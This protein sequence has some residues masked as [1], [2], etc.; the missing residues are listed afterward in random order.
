[1][2]VVVAV[3]AFRAEA[4]GMGII[5]LMAAVAVLRNL[6]LVIAAAMAGET[7]DLRVHAQEVIA[8]FLQM[9]VFR[10]L[11]LLGHVAL[12]AIL[13]ARAAMLIVG[14]MTAIAA[15]RHRL[16]AA[17]DVAGIAGHRQVRAGQLEFRLVVIE[18]SASPA[19]RAVAL[20]AFLLELPAVHVIGF[21]AA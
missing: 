8:G 17:A 3:L 11:P 5:G 15:L 9:I 1:M 20:A 14:G 2:L 4:R 16:V 18:L 6:V 19:Q 7:V 12:C 21:M 10:G 13:A